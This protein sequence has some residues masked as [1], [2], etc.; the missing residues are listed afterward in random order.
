VSAFVQIGLAFF[1]AWWRGD[2]SND[3]A[4]LALY[5]A[6]KADFRTGLVTT[7]LEAIASE[8]GWHDPKRTTTARRLA[9]LS[10]LGFV[11]S[12]VRGRGKRRFHV[13]RPTRS[14]LRIGQ[15]AQQSAANR[16]AEEAAPRE[17]FQAPRAANGAAAEETRQEH[18]STSTSAR[19]VERSATN[20][21]K[22][23]GW[24]ENLNAYT[25]CRLV[26]GTHGF[27]HKQDPLGMD[28]PPFD[29]PYERPTREQVAAALGARNT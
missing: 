12:D 5:L 19:D 17:G 1:E 24:I 21:G 15:L 28:K 13:I 2:V 16:E 8:L 9:Q 25:G 7:T 20:N 14:L 3:E 23:S 10:E 4:L 29:W 26:R 6:G 27:A 22:S 18:L 11:Q